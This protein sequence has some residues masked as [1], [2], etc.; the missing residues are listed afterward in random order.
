MIPETFK[1]IAVPSRPVGASIPVAFKE[2]TSI[3]GPRIRVFAEAPANEGWFIFCNTS[4]PDIPEDWFP[5][6][7]SARLDTLVYYDAS[8]KGTTPKWW[9]ATRKS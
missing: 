3:I 4:N 2:V 6:P 8:P 9:R 1:T 7:S 5:V